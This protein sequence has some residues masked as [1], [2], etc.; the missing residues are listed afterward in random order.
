MRQIMILK[1]MYKEGNRQCQRRAQSKS[2]AGRLI[3]VKGT[4]RRRKVR[5]CVN[6]VEYGQQIIHYIE[7]FDGAFKSLLSIR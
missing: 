1:G 7:V 5:K 3:F 4:E 6:N 2:T